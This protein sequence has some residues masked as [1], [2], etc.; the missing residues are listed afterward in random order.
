VLGHENLDVI[1]EVGNAVDRVRVGDRV[2]LRFNFGC[3][4]CRNCERGLT[5]FCLTRNSHRTGEREALQL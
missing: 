4:F 5:G 1:T 2:C 3:G